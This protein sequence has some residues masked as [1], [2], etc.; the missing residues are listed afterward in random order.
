MNAPWLVA[1]L[2]RSAAAVSDPAAVPAFAARDEGYGGVLPTLLTLGG[3]WNA[4]VVP[5]SR[6]DL[7]PVVLGFVVFVMAAAGV[8]LWWRRCAV[9]RALV[10]VGVLA[11]VI[12][13]VGVVAPGALAW[14][15]REVPGAGLFRDGQRYLGPLVL[16]ESIAFGAALAAALRV[17]PLKWIVGATAAL[18]PIAALPSLAG[19]DGLKSAQ[20]P[21]DWVQ[22]RRV[23]A[24]DDRPGE[25]IPWP[26]ESYRAPAWNDR[27]PVLDPMPRYFTKPSIVPDELIVGGRRLAGEDPRATAI[28]TALREAVRTGTDPTDVLRQQGV[29]WLVV[30]REAGGPSPR[31]YTPQLAEVFTGQT[32]IVY[33]LPETPTRQENRPWA[34]VLV[35]AA[36]T[37][38]AAVLAA[39]AVGAITRRN[40]VRSKL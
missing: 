11:V 37:L 9:M 13:M 1:G 29:G 14:A 22:A 39:A 16:I 26:F 6:G 40:R 23:L 35:L 30:D 25:F 21:A 38:A 4:D 20:Y 3:V 24:N 8:A 17:V 31:D 2:A 27:R 10:V 12:G 5:D 19:G 32:V 18:V 36:W 15:V 34:V 7:V 33:R 28:A